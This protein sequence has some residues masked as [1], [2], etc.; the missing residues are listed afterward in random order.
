MFGVKAQ[1]DERVDVQML[2]CSN[3]ASVLVLGPVIDVEPTYNWQLALT[4]PDGPQSWT[5]M[6]IKP[7]VHSTKSIK[8]PIMTMPGSSCR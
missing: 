1:E 8:A 7:T 5:L 6:T 2:C 4:L 3:H